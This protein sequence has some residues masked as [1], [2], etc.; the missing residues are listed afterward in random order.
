MTRAYLALGSNVG[1]RAAFLAAA[2]HEVERA[3]IQIRRASAVHCTAP[4]GVHDQPDFLNQ[5]LEVS[6][7]L[8]PLPLLDTC[9]GIERA[10]GRTPAP[11]WGPREVDI[12]VLLYGDLQLQTERL[13][14]PHPGLAERP[15]VLELLD[16]LAP[17]LRPPGA[18]WTVAERLREL[19]RRSPG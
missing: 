1:D 19:A 18:T 16:Q 15:F 9:Q 2:R 8:E 5:V 11:R 6:T 7:E 4:F 13:T 12:D 10:L 14:I 17:D 3:G